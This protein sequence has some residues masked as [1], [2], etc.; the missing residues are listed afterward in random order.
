MHTNNI[1]I[2][3]FAAWTQH[4]TMESLITYGFH[5]NPDAEGLNAFSSPKLEE[6]K[7]IIMIIYYISLL[8][9]Y[10]NNCHGRNKVE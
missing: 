9:I 10:L 8:F 5:P 7:A 2:D 3:F 4:P 1:I 6:R